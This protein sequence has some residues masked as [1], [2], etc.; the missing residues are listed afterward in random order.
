MQVMNQLRAA[1]ARPRACG[2]PRS[3]LDG[4]DPQ[5]RRIRGVGAA[6]PRHARGAKQLLDRALD[7]KDTEQVRIAAISVARAEPRRPLDR[8][9]SLASRATAIAQIRAAALVV[10]R[11]DRLRARAASRCSTPPA[12]ARPRIARRRDLGPRRS[13]DDPR[14][15]GAARR[16][17]P[18]PAIRTVAQ[19]AIYSSYNAGPEVDVAL[20]LHSQRPERER[21]DEDHRRVTAPHP[22]HATLDDATEQ[23]VTALVGAPYGGSRL[24]A[25]TT[26]REDLGRR[27]AL[28]RE[29]DAEHRS[30]AD[31]VLDLDPA[32]VLLDDAGA[33]GEP[34]PGAALA[35]L[36]RVERVEDLVL[37]V[38]RDADRRCPRPTNTTNACSALSSS[39]GRVRR[40]TLGLDR[41]ASRRRAS[42]APR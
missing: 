32:V 22:R 30:A 25:G 33:H 2:S 20:D 8:R 24:R 36:R 31:G 6:E 40:T 39:P 1:P 11:P 21:V 41:R 38:G 15:S 5:A 14:A 13:M 42:P 10:A 3:M 37:D 26:R 35:L 29:V 16:T 4:K 17:D 28:R 23:K 19:T 9:S 34:E 27:L 12:A 7:S 18:R